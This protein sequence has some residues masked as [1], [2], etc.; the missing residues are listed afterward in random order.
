MDQKL[1]NISWL[2]IQFI[3]KKNEIVEGRIELGTQNGG[4]TICE[5]NFDDKDH[6]A[7][8]QAF[9]GKDIQVSNIF[10][11]QTY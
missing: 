8:N 7:E 5:M 6:G 4:K 2:L 9:K 11:F 1:D 10:L 3:S